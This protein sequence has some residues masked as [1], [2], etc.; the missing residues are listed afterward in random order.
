MA[1]AQESKNLYSHFTEGVTPIEDVYYIG[2]L[3][4]TG[5]L[6]DYFFSDRHVTREVFGTVDDYRSQQQSSTHQDL[7]ELQ[8]S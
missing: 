1:T 8:A 3:I 4:L 6:G 2:H 7:R 5:E